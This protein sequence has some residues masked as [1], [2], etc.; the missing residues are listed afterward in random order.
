MKNWAYDIMLRQKVAIKSI[1]FNSQHFTVA[2]SKVPRGLI[3]WYFSQRLRGLSLMF[4]DFL[5]KKN[6]LKRVV[7]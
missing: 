2:Y 3:E 7:I 1:A 4:L 5:N 6:H